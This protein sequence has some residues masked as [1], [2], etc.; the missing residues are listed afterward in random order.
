MK[1]WH[2]EQEI[3]RRKIDSH[4]ACRIIKERK[5]EMLKRHKKSYPINSSLFVDAEKKDGFFHKRPFGRG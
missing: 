3:A 4:K 1:W 2:V 5:K